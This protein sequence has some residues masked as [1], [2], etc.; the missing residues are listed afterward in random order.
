LVIWPSDKSRVGVYSYGF[1]PMWYLNG[2]ATVDIDDLA[3]LLMTYYKEASNPS[4]LSESQSTFKISR[5]DD[6]VTLD[7]CDKDL[8]N[9]HVFD[10]SKGGT[11]V[12]YYGESKGG[13]ESREWVYEQKDNAWV[14][15]T[16]TLNSRWSTPL[17]SGRTKYT[18]K[19][20]FTENILNQPVDASEFTME[21]LGVQVGDPVS[22]HRLGLL[23][24]YGGVE[25][26]PFDSGLRKETPSVKV[27]SSAQ[28]AAIRKEERVVPERRASEDANSRPQVPEGTT[29]SARLSRWTSAA[30]IVT[31]ALSSSVVCFLLLRRRRR[32]RV[33]S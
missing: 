29:R 4:L 6:L 16:F 5:D 13:T 15:M 12:K 11:L 30:I 18:R 28:G 22:D 26:L 3:D 17:P 21:R 31:V 23:Y 27:D 19:V 2:E 33:R 8:L 1:D 7:I 20:T 32:I 24:N 25:D 10:L 14:P 9:R